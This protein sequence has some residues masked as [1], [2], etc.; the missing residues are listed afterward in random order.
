MLYGAISAMVGVGLIVGT[1]T[2]RTAAK[3]R[4]MH[5]LV[6]SGLFLL[7]AG[8]ALLGAFR[9][10]LT[11]ALSTFTIGFAIAFV[12]VPAQ[13]LSQRDT[14][15]AM[16]GRISSTFLAMFSLAQVLGMLISGVLADR[17]GIR[18]LFLSCAAT[19]AILAAA[20]FFLLRPR[21]QT[22]AA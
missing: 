10:T 18:Q 7:G 21:P 2:V 6:L 14:P 17:L 5:V 19:V 4:S 1:Q 11:A 22:D 3:N 20:G 15:P 12:I 13:T 8:A 9:Y 16:Q